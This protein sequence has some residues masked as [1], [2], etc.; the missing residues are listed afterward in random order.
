MS[1]MRYKSDWPLNFTMPLA[2]PEASPDRPDAATLFVTGAPRSQELELRASSHGAYIPVSPAGRQQNT[3][4]ES[5]LRG[6]GNPQSPRQHYVRRRLGALLGRR[7]PRRGPNWNVS[8]FRRAT[9]GCLASF[10]NG[11]GHTDTTD[12]TQLRVRMM[13]SSCQGTGTQFPCILCSTLAD[14][15]N[16][17]DSRNLFETKIGHKWNLKKMK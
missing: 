7:G 4:K 3:T 15:V 16:N 6:L 8:N 17:S 11:A 10:G 2:H 12:T 9:E 5:P 1:T 13:E 14:S